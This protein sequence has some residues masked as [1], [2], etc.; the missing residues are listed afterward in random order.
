ML[1]TVL[2]GDFFFS[3]NIFDTQIYERK[4]TAFFPQFIVNI[5]VN[6]KFSS[7]IY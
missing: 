4:I 3:G 5:K 6:L 1:S 2:K 7:G